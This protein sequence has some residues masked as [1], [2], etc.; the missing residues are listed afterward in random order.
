M[1]ENDLFVDFFNTY[2]K[3]HILKDN[4]LKKKFPNR[5]EEMHLKQKFRNLITSL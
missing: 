5:Y 1:N 4:D 2:V 3:I